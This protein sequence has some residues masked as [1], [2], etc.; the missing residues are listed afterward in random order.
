MKTETGD[1]GHVGYK[2]NAE[3]AI[4][5]RTGAVMTI[6]GIIVLHFSGYPYV[7]NA[8]VSALS[9]LGI[10]EL[11]RAVKQ[12]TLP[13]MLVLS[14]VAVCLCVWRIPYY[15]LVLT[16]A[17]VLALIAFSLMMRHSGKVRFPNFASILPCTV[18]LPLFFYSFVEIRQQP[19]GLYLL[20][21]VMLGC[22][23]NDVAAYFVGKAIGT[24]K[25]APE[26]SPGKTVEGGLGGF[27]ISTVLLEIL[28]HIF[29][30]CTGIPVRY[31]TLLVYLMLA[32]LIGQFG[33]L[34][35]SVI[36]RS[37]GIKDFGKILPGHGGILDRFDSVLFVAPFAVIFCRIAG[38]FF[39]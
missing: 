5:V 6:V 12:Y 1:A 18:M 4:R 38:G 25:L 17:W 9:V 11:L 21:L 15:T 24:H 37:V 29:S 27:M 19:Y 7:L 36:K 8:A 30:L 23:C 33:D 10:Y 28:A 22:I 34:S 35:M 16:I 26:I 32:S 14:F 3:L 13:R 20:I 39:R 31:G 2:P